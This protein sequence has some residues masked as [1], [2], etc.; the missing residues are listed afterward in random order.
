MRLLMKTLSVALT[1]AIPLTVFCLGANIATRMPD[2][3]QY[4]FK[5][6][7][8]LKNIDLNKN[9]DEMGEFISDFMMGKEAEFQLALDDDDR[10][11]MIFNEKEMAAAA[12]ARK[13]MNVVGIIG[14]ISLILMVV[15]FVMLKRYGLEK[16]IRKR[17]K[18]G[19][20]IY[21]GLLIAYLGGFFAAAKTGHTLPDMLGYVPQEED[22]LPQIITAELSRGL[23]LSVAAVSTV[24][25][26]ILWYIMY[27]ITEPKKIFSRSYYG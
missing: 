14:F 6:T 20:I 24:M 5:A 16:E 18:W 9:D 25:M 10:P 7:D 1:V 8:S 15:A 17:F 2:V 12:Q 27:K 11:Q 22:I 4:Q 23:L 19:A 26:A 13:D 21:V 3:Y